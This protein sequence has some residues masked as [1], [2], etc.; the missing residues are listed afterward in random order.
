MIVRVIVV[1][2]RTAVDSDRCFSLRGRPSKGKRK[3]IRARDHARGRREE[4]EGQLSPSRASRALARKK[5]FPPSL[6]TPATQATDVSK[7]GAEVIVRVS[8]NTSVDS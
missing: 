3:R 7:T 4:G 2:N 6:S 1:L 5:K 8:C